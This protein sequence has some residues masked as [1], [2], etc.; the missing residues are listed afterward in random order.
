MNYFIIDQARDAI[1]A[2][3]LAGEITYCNQSASRMLEYDD[4]ELPGKNQR[5]LLPDDG[6]DDF[7]VAREVILFNKP[8]EPFQT[9]RLTKHNERI[10]VSVQYSPMTGEE[11]MLVGISQVIRKMNHFEMASS[12][13]QDLLETA[14]D[15]MVIVNQQGQIV[16]VNAQTE[17]LFSYRKEELL[18][19][20]VEILIPDSFIENHRQYRQHYILHPKTRSMGQGTELYG[21]QKDGSTFPVEISLS[22]LITAEGTFV[23]AAIRDISDRKRAELKFRKLLESA[24]D[25]MV[26]VSESGLI[27]LV[28]AQVEN[29]F[30]YQKK[31]I[32]GSPVE[33]LIPTRFRRQ[34]GKHRQSFFSNPKIR[35]MGVGLELFGLHKNGHEFPVEI[36]L[37]PLETEEGVLVSAAIRDISQ[38]KKTEKAMHTYNNELQIKNK[39]LEQFAYVASHDL[40]EPLRTVK[41][42]IALLDKQYSERFDENAAQYFKFISQATTRMEELVIG[43]LDYSRIGQNKKM[44]TVNCQTL[45][46]DIRQDLSSRIED[47]RTSFEVDHLPVIRGYKTELRLLFQNLIAN[48]I[49]F[50]KEGCQPHIKISAQQADNCSQFQVQD[51]GIG[52][53]DKHRQ[54]IFVIFQRLHSR[55]KYEGTGIGLAHCQKIVDLHGGKIWVDSQPG[56]GSSFYFTIQTGD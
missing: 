33:M 32:I 16:L 55:D 3:D 9:H 30:G 43:L 25:A 15:A 41:N 54:K 12:R 28:N 11:G 17:R 45:I 8:S 39:E 36:S 46:D 2:L 29:I 26:I 18:G 53:A 37:S 50:R 7:E 56:E 44:T 40:Q 48:A 38:R 13:A 47:T 35:P 49:K 27:Q 23:S 1:I 4:Q 6:T 31:E 42:F 14:P 19:K 21:K 24:P 51:N 34:H 52:I 22:P 5:C 20:A 10:A